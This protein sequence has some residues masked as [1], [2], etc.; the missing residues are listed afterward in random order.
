MNAPITAHDETD[1]TCVR[2]KFTGPRNPPVLILEVP[3]VVYALRS[4]EHP[5]KLRIREGIT[6]KVIP[7]DIGGFLLGHSAANPRFT[8]ADRAR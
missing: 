1:C 8:G 3:T 7:S 6:S 2:G 4:R 5:F